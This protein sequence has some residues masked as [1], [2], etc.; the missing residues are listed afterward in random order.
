LTILHALIVRSDTA[1]GHPSV[2]LWGERTLSPADDRIVRGRRRTR[3]DPPVHPFAL[4]PEEL[5]EAFGE[6]GETGA[7]P[8][9][10]FSSTTAR[11]LLPSLRGRPVSSWAAS[12][13][14]ASAL[15]PWSAAAIRL[16]L[17]VSVP[18][19]ATLSAYDPPP[20]LP[21]IGPGL[22]FLERY[23]KFVLRLL[24]QH[25]FL[26]SVRPVGAQR[27][28]AEW[29]ALLLSS[30]DQQ[31]AAEL[32]ARMPPSLW[33]AED[34]TGAP[35]LR[36]RIRD[37]LDG[38]VDE[39][40]RAWLAD[41]SPPTEVTGDSAN[42]WIA[43]LASPSPIFAPAS[44]LEAQEIVRG[45]E[46]WT[47]G[48]GGPG[49][50]DLGYRVG[51][52]IDPPRGGE[53]LT[54]QP[55]SS[56]LP[57]P[58]RLRSYLQSREDPS[59][60]I[61]ARAILEGAPDR[62]AHRGRVVER[63]QETL[64]AELSRAARVY[65]PL[66]PLLDQDRP[67]SLEIS[68]SAAYDFLRDGAPRLVECGFGVRTPPWWSRPQ[69][70]L[71]AQ[72][73]AREPEGAGL[74]GLA[75]L[76]A[77]DL[78]IALGGTVVS[79]EELE[80]LAALKVPLVRWR[81][82][83]VEVRREDVDAALRALARAKA[84][85]FSVAEALHIAAEGSLGGLPLTTFRVTGALAALFGR[86]VEEERIGDLRPPRGLRGELRPYQLRG[87]AWAAFLRRFG[88]GGCLADD[89]GLGKTIQTLAL[90]VRAI[91]EEPGSGP[92]LLVAPTSV[93]SNWQ[94]ESARF[95]PGLRVLVHHD[96]S[97]QRG[98]AFEREVRRHDLVLTSYALLWR[99]AELLRSVPWDTVVLDEAQNIKNPLSKV[100]RAARGLRSRHRL[101]LTGTP[102]ENRLTELWSLFEFLDP[103]Y[104]GPLPS[105]RER[106][107]EPIERFEDAGVARRLQSLV[108]PLVLRRL[109]SDP[110]IAPELPAKVEQRIFCP[111]T[112]EQATLYE[113]TVKDMMERIEAAD[114]MDRRGLILAALTKLKQVCDHPALLLH[115]RS[116]IPGRSGKLERLEEMLIEALSEGDRA[117][118]FTQFAEMGAMVRDRLSERFHVEVPFLHGGLSPKERD[119][120]LDRF[121][122]PAGPPIFVLSLKAGGFGLNLTRANRVFHFDRWWNPAV[123]DQATDRAHR[124][125][126]VERVMVAKFVTEGTLEERIEELLTRK[127][128]LAERILT[129]GEAGLTELSTSQLLA[130]F[131]LRADAVISDSPGPDNDRTVTPI[132]EDA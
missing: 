41:L 9:P 76:L 6:L 34:G 59:L 15:A 112:R 89:M 4:A 85:R 108:R 98:T 97:R 106:F 132:A 52:R 79:P 109:K 14:R 94:R 27:L 77:Y 111:L 119:L 122:S 44:D 31:L 91:E 87:V 99:D 33:A 18:W 45:F 42:R 46:A 49:A 127:R 70:G 74:F 105:F 68:L 60:Q 125:G 102:V 12:E 35:V 126:Q 50:A 130:L 107:A 124:I 65:P 51:F 56:A 17:G 114:G 69:A 120:V 47:G 63:P 16:S 95:A 103:G 101:V 55:L 11:L 92:W 64:L 43:A 21:R 116:A 100:A 117:L 123:E 66:A 62:L 121:R 71:T 90:R 83:W 67:E 110:A 1:E 82:Q 5:V 113:A 57:G 54:V 20:E 53:D 81:G 7:D 2:A 23:A 38:T 80:R 96:A 10:A 26:P 39:I 86:T 104:L 29:R 115:D 32:H 48:A 37:L 36:P 30:E 40:A 24:A 129:S 58:W 28:G 118:V 72:V 19:L 73:E 93:V 128:A 3:T 25:R 22:R 13:G 88:L 131:E 84:G 75:G 61:P 8:L 78:K